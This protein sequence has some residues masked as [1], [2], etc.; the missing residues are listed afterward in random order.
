MRTA[1]PREG[2]DHATLLPATAALAAALVVLALPAALRP[3][4]AAA[5][6][7]P[8]CAAIEND[9]ERLACYDRALRAAA[10]ATPAA[11][12]AHTAPATAPSTAAPA[13]TESADAR[14]DRTI[15]LVIVSVTSHPGRQT[16]FTAEDGA[17]YVQTDA[18]RVMGLPKTPFEAELKP[19]SMGSYFLAPKDR[20]RA[21]R[22]RSSDR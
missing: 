20:S 16:I 5:Q 4:R 9:A 12:A 3:Q 6:S 13:P 19:G 14:D 7:A 18:Q 8:Q 15:P 2:Q 17:T 21:I 11:P 10:P 22:V 1:A